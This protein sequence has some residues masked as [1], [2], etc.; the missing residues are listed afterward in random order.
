MWFELLLNRLRIRFLYD[1]SSA[2]L[3]NTIFCVFRHNLNQDI[4]YF[5][6][7]CCYRNYFNFDN[8][9][10]KRYFEVF[11]S[12]HP[13]PTTPLKICPIKSVAML[14]GFL[15]SNKK[16]LSTIWEILSSPSKLL[17][18]GAFYIWALL[19]KMNLYWTLMR[20]SV[21]QPKNPS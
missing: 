15:H 17:K 10:E 19:R 3:L 6:G 12:S 21:L 9:P 7:L 16:I 2:L 20:K 18:T 8:W 13:I 11:C 14:K 5:D 4:K 1:L